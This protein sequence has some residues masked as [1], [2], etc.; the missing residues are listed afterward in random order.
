MDQREVIR[1]K[2][3]ELENRD[4]KNIDDYLKIE[5]EIN[6]LRSKYTIL[7]AQNL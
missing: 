6:R 2:I 1:N 5:Q 7:P 3:R 4:P